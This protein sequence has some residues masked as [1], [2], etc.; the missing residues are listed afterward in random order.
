MS[1]GS[2]QL[3]IT[4]S[5]FEVVKTIMGE[6][7]SQGVD[8]RKA[9]TAG[10]QVGTG[11]AGVIPPEL[12]SLVPVDTPFFNSCARGGIANK[13]NGGGRQGAR[14]VF[15]ETL[16]NIN[17]IQPDI[18]VPFDQAGALVKIQNQYVSSQVVP[19]AL[20]GTVSED[21]LATGEGV[22]DVLA[23]DTLQTINQVLIGMDIH[24]LGAQNFPLPTIGTPTITASTSGG[25]IAASTTIY[26]KCCALSLVNYYRG[27]SGAVGSEGSTTTSSSSSIN[28][29]TGFVAAVKGASAYEWFVGSSTGAE[30]YYTTTTTNTVTITAIPTVAANVPA[31]PGI[32]NGPNPGPN[33]G[34]TSMP[35]AD[36]SYQTYWQNG[37]LPSIVAD[38]ASMPDQLGVGLTFTNLT[39]PGAGTSQGA[40]YKSLDGAQL[41]VQGAA[42]EQIDV[43]NKT[44]Y[45]TYQ[46]SV[47][48]LLMGS[49]TITDIANALLDN[50]QAVTW[51]VPTD[52]SGRA[53]LVA[54]GAV[55]IYLNKTV[56]GKPIVLELHPHLPPG[57]VIAVVDEVP[58][59]GANMKATMAVETLID[60]WR[61]DYGVSRQVGVPNGGPRYDFEVR[62][63]QAFKCPAAPV[64]GVLS[65]IGAGIA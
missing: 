33:Q 7:M 26:V 10:I 50:P 61:F 38:Y 55:A 20:G 9:A 54:G 42:L 58:F 45:D 14:F 11:I 19:M 27:G 15:W 49:Q 31:L 63:L 13:I 16:L 57:A 47:T 60:F 23:V 5:T 30:Y 64:M 28:S 21:A 56:N 39:T 6:A 24:Q 8:V 12:V 40:Y 52:A 34:P 65:N 29:A 3:G 1:W 36:T 18:G 25:A 4:E 35:T 37:L 22:A 62:S 17:S 32:Y 51:L 44:I 53:R 43:M 41:S 59:P 2:D 46:L 48:R